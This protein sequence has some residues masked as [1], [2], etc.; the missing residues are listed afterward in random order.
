MTPRSQSRDHDCEMPP[1]TAADCSALHPGSLAV[2]PSL[3]DR[4]R[5]SRVFTRDSA[6]RLQ[7]SVRNTESRPSRNR[8][9]RIANRLV[10]KIPFAQLRVYGNTFVTRSH[11]PSAAVCM[12][13]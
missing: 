8:Q 9:A 10:A 4:E 5:E 13:Y 3:I 1:W 11:F 12:N 7:K 6:R 2:L